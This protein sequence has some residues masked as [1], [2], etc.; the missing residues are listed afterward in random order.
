MLIRNWARFFFFSITSHSLFLFYSISEFNSLHIFFFYCHQL[1][2]PIATG[3]TTTRGGRSAGSTRDTA[4]E[5]AATTEGSSARVTTTPTSEPNKKGHP[6][7]FSS[8][9]Q[10]A[11]CLSPHFF[12]SHNSPS[13]STLTLH[14]LAPPPALR[15]HI[16]PIW[17]LATCCHLL[18]DYNKPFEFLV[19]C[20]NYAVLHLLFYLITS[21]SLSTS[22]CVWPFSEKEKKV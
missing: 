2:E 12:N 14:P 21:P 15:G 6:V 4:T 11:V 9:L 19:F 18:P 17:G 10:A 13:R 16:S 22:L 20:P 8:V 5:R 3:A 1:G 7:L